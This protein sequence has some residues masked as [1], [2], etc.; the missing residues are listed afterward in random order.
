ML[1]LHISCEGASNTVGSYLASEAVQGAALTLEGV[2]DIHGCDCLAAGV[3]GVSD[4]ITDD[5]LEEDLQDGASL[6][7]DE[8]GDTLHATTTSE[9][10]DGG[11]GDALD[12]VAKH[13]AVALSAS[14]AESF[15]SFATSRH[16]CCHQQG[17][18]LLQ[19]L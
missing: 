11:L 8:A 14:L 15:T 6:L 18:Y 16:L 19:A 9:T 4:G 13:L 10:A 7:I 17:N 2:D 1:V 12:V 5:V 3:L